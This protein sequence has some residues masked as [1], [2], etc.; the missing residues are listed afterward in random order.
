MAITYKTILFLTGKI[1]YISTVRRDVKD[2]RWEY[3]R[4]SSTI[5]KVSRLVVQPKRT[6]SFMHGRETRAVVLSIT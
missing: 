6:S 2:M 1:I 4:L 3:V 5:G